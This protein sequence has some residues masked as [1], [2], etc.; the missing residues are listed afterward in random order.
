MPLADVKLAAQ[1][2]PYFDSLS[3]T[4][5]P[6]FSQLWTVGAGSDLVES[7]IGW[8][9]KG[10]PLS[11]QQPVCATTD[12]AVIVIDNAPYYQTSLFLTWKTM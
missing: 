8:V 9:R 3:W 4:E 11:Y 10:S 1:L 7:R 2:C 6:Q 5:R 12:D